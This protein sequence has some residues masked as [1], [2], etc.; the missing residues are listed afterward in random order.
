MPAGREK[1]TKPVSNSESLPTLSPQTANPSIGMSIPDTSEFEHFVGQTLTE[2]QSGQRDLRNRMHRLEE[3][4]NDSIEFQSERIDGLELKMKEL[5][6]LTEVVAKAEK[7]MAD[8]A[9]QVNKLERFSRRNNLRIIGFPQQKGED[10][11]A[12]S[13]DLLKEKFQMPDVKLERAHRD[14]PKM[15][16]KPQHL[17]VKLNC[18]QDKIKILQQQRQ[19]LSSAPFFCVEDL[20]RADLQEKRKWSAQVSSASSY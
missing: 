1:P 17:L 18:Y 16:G 15:D 12:L 19:V 5:D 8:H 6:R 11:L 7:I 2:I 10:C 9:E 13:C 4:I 3:N 14:G 20:T